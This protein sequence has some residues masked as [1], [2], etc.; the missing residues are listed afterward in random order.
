MDSK[1]LF[2]ILAISCCLIYI[3]SLHNQLNGFRD[4]LLIHMK[5]KQEHDRLMYNNLH[6]IPEIIECSK[7]FDE[8][9]LLKERIGQD[10]FSEM[11]DQD[12][13]VKPYHWNLYLDSIC[14]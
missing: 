13:S 10:Y 4:E 7:L 11:P 1:T 3:I 12:S 5:F 14:K 8:N 9:I 6:S 2:F